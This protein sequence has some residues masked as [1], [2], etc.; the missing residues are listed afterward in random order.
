[1]N[2]TQ[3]PLK[4]SLFKAGGGGEDILNIWQVTFAYKSLIT[5]ETALPQIIMSPLLRLYLDGSMIICFFFNFL[6]KAVNSSFAV[7]KPFEEYV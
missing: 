5:A 4:A 7:H 2:A 3:E 6:N 1:M